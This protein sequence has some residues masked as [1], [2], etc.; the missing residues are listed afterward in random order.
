MA[1]DACVL[2]SKLFVCSTSI[3][4]CSGGSWDPRAH[5][6]TYVP[7]AT[8]A[9]HLSIYV[10]HLNTAYKQWRYMSFSHG[11]HYLPWIHHSKTVPQHRC[12]PESLGSIQLDRLEGMSG[13]RQAPQD[14]RSIHMG[15]TIWRGSI[16]WLAGLGVHPEGVQMGQTLSSFLKAAVQILGGPIRGVPSLNQW[17]N[18]HWLQPS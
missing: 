9:R 3:F 2:A 13:A 1:I 15:W 8:K 11:L 4:I 5:A 10:R 16:R 12:S 7:S 14:G 6:D 18:F 17:Q